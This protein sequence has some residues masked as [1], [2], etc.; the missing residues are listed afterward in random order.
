MTQV[1]N[2]ILNP[3]S[4]TS[5]HLDKTS[6][7]YKFVSTQAIVA[8]LESHGWQVRETKAVNTKKYQGFQKHVIKMNHPDYT[9]QDKSL[10]LIISNS[11]MGNS[12]VKLTMGIFRFI[13][14]NG[15]VV[16]TAF[17]NEKVR[18]VGY[19]HAKLDTALNNLLKQTDK[20][21][22]HITAMSNRQLTDEEIKLLASNFANERLKG[23]D[24]VVKVDV[25]KMLDIYRAE[26]QARD[27]FTVYNVLQEKVIRSGI[28][29][30]T[31]KIVKDDQGNIIDIKQVERKTRQVNSIDTNIKLNANMFDM[32]SHML[33]VNL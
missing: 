18:H 16:G 30:T 2:N 12:S 8:R 22:D 27:L 24:N 21:L 23:I 25:N 10:E 13:C 3:V 1:I 9:Y 31:E 7:K 29:Y 33:G 28:N 17:Y 6:N 32:A 11:H 20:L 4:Q 26:D 19:T 5:R 15:L 14:E